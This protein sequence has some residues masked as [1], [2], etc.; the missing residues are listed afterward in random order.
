MSSGVA[1]EP[2]VPAKPL[3][4][5]PSFPSARPR[6]ASA[7]RAPQHGRVPAKKKVARRA[8]PRAAA[9][10]GE[11]DAFLAAL[12]HPLRP[13]LAALRAAI[14]GADASIGEGIQWN[15]PSFRTREWFATMN[16]RGKGGEARVWLILHSGA[17]SKR[18]VDVADPS[19]LLKRL[20]PDRCLIAFE[21]AADV[22]AKTRALQAI[23]RAWIRDL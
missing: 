7:A 23:V 2:S 20:A 21:N 5:R 12:D 8:R 3:A 1:S 11:V 14:R 19:G 9:A 16:L 13:A 4:F 18:A 22:R 6:L 17:K 15:A 10:P